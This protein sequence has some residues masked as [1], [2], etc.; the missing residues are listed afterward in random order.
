MVKS[1]SQSTPSTRRRSARVA[2]KHRACKI[3]TVLEQANLLK[4]LVGR[5]PEAKRR[6]AEAEAI[7]ATVSSRLASLREATVDVHHDPF[8]Y[9][10][11]SDEL[12]SLA[13]EAERASAMAAEAVAVFETIEQQ[14]DKVKA[15]LSA[16]LDGAEGEAP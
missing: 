15:L 16:T 3:Q 14:R 9:K 5:A 8:T 4:E 12:D 6:L 7:N 10:V 2:G 13:H 1:S 11:V